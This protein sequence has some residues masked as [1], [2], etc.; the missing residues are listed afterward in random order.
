MAASWPWW[1]IGASVDQAPRRPGWTYAVVAAAS[2]VG[3]LGVGHL[4]SSVFDPVAS[5]F[6]VPLVFVAAT[7]PHTL[8]RLAR[9]WAK[10]GA[11]SYPAYL[12]H[13]LVLYGVKAALDV[14]HVPSS[15]PV[16]A[17]VL[18]ASL[19]AVALVSKIVARWVEAP[20]LAMRTRL[21]RHPRWTTAL[22]AVQFGLVPAGLTYLL[23][24]RD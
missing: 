18:P 15:W 19:L 1:G 20:C 16:V 21:P 14:A 2:L 8:P 13:M 10:L 4:R 6:T 17:V 23:L 11:L 3:L 12:L 9:P 22:A 24:I 5:L 7:A